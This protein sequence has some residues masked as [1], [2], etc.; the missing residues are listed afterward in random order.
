MNEVLKDNSYVKR[1]IQLSDA[2][3]D[4]YEFHKKVGPILVEMGNDKE[5]L[6]EVIRRNFTDE[7]YLSQTW[8]LY[9]IPYFF[10]FE[11]EH[12]NIKIHLFPRHERKL[13]GIAAHCIHHHNNYLLTSNAF[14]GSGYESMLF[15]KDLNLNES[16][17]TAKMKIRKHF[18]QKDWNPSLVDSW[19]PHVVFIPELLSATLVVWTPDKKRTTDNLRANPL[20]KAIKG[21]LRWA[22]HSFGL[23]EKFGIAAKNTYQFYPKKN[24]V[25]F[26]AIEE[27]EY[28]APTRAA[29]GPEVD[30]YSMRMIFNFLQLADLVDVDFL[31]QVRSNA[32]TP[33]YYHKWL[34]MAI[35]QQKVPEVFHREEINIPIRAYT[36]SDIQTA[37]N[38]IKETA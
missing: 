6:K 7:G 26:K 33:S 19:E 5:F 14:F 30:E 24:N 28:F 34:D 4:R 21:P 36:R 25:G 31:K 1:I 38:R 8:S 37:A 9:N 32:I 29:K 22:I 20:L 12:I 16:D 10:V 23:T 35:N 2:E 11:N 17:L 15:E 3:D 13:D 27:N 18:H